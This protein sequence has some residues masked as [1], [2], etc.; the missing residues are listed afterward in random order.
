MKNRS[1]PFVLIL[2][3]VLVTACAAPNAPSPATAAP[4]QGVSNSSTPR[5]EKL[6]P[7]NIKSLTQLFPPPAADGSQPTPLPTS[8]D[9]S[10]M[11][12]DIFFF[13]KNGLLNWTSTVS[14]SLDFA[15]A[16]DLGSEPLCQKVSLSPQGQG[17][18]YLL[19]TIAGEGEFYLGVVNNLE[20]SVYRGTQKQSSPLLTVAIPAG[21]KVLNFNY[22]PSGNFVDLH[23]K[24]SDPVSDV[25]Y[26]AGAGSTPYEY[27]FCRVLPANEVKDLI[28]LRSRDGQYRLGSGD[29]PEIIETANS[30]TAALLPMDI[31]NGY[32]DLA[33][34]IN[35]P[36]GKT[37]SFVN[38]V[39]G[40]DKTIK[41]N[42]LLRF[43]LAGQKLASR[44]MINYDQDAENQVKSDYQVSPDGTLLAVSSLGQK[45]YLVDISTGTVVNTLEFNTPP[46]RVAFSK[47][48]NVLAVAFYDH[49]IKIFGLVAK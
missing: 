12:E 46:T 20:F 16:W 47:D 22:S 15:C 36:D 9:G 33:S 4:D 23:L 42:E 8:W 41:S 40:D 38:L 17:G 44:T 19:L 11:G 2:L 45:V 18:E 26:V 24:K 10:I 30:K 31:L 37:V 27:N 21:S 25:L 13:D 1:L 3:T 49:Q 43:D 39:L 7:A 35:W 34:L 28:C 29:K 6:T 48:G 5:L 14:G 32:P